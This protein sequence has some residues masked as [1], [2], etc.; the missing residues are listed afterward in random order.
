LKI[1][2]TKSLTVLA[3]KKSLNRVRDFAE[4]YGPKYGLNM[5][6]VNGFRLS[7]DEI[8]TNI[9][10]YAYTDR[11]IPG[12]IHIEI[13]R[14]EGTVVTRIIDNGKHFDYSTVVDPD[15]NRYIEERRR[16]GFGI[17]LVRQLNESVKYERV[18]NSNIL[19]LINEV[20]P[21][22]SLWH[23][24]QTNLS[25]VQMP[26][27][28]RFTLIAAL[29]ITL[30]TAGTFY[31]I[32]HLQ[33]NA[34]RRQYINSIVSTLR[35]FSATS[36]DYIL[37]ERDLFLAE[38]IYEITEENKE[39]K[40]LTVTNAD[41]R[42]VADTSL[43]N[44]GLQ[45]NSPDG[46]VPLENQVHL[47]QEYSD[48]VLGP[49]MYFSVPIRIVDQVIGKLFL[50]IQ[51]DEMMRIVL[52]SQDKRRIVTY[53]GMFWVLGIIGIYFL[54][55][56]FVAPI[57]KITEE[58]AR[59]SREGTTGGFHFT[60]V[61]EF[62]E[63]S[64]AF[65]QMMREIT[66]SQLRLTDQDRLKR[67]MQ[68]AQ[69]IQHTLLPKN[70]PKT[71]GYE[72]AAEYDAAMEVGGDYY[73]FFEVDENTV[74]MAVGDVS[75]KG[76]G[77]AFVMS[78]VRTALRLE[79]RGE[80]NAAEVLLKI[81]NSLDGEFKKGMYM[82]LFYIILDSRRRVINYASAG[83][84]P[85]ILYRGKTNQLFR[86]NPKGFPIGLNIGDNKLFKKNIKNEKLNLSKDDMLLI[87][88]DGITE[89]MNPEREVY[90]EERLFNLIKQHHMST[91]RE[92]ADKLTDDIRIFTH[93]HPQNDDIT[94]IVIKEK[95]KYSDLLF[96]K[97]VKLFE[98]VEQEG[99][100]VKKACETIGFSTTTY[101]NLKKLRDKGGIE[102]LKPQE[103]DK[104]MRV[105]DQSLSRKILE[106]VS[107][108]PDH[109][110]KKIKETLE[111]DYYGNVDI[112]TKLIYRELNR[113]KLSTK[114][115]RMAYVK[116]KRE[117]KVD[118]RLSLP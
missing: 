13:T 109:S 100:S 39:F 28:I 90:G 113:L 107:D 23:K 53:I 62:A 106:V 27:K 99:Y 61:G 44:L 85:M 5:R 76:I 7:L 112:D 67:E 105:L 73:D 81:N 30:I 15:L 59:V 111:T 52:L 116:R 8:C 24:I 16:G 21:R 72:I 84:T 79:A 69:S 38:M 51:T 1:G 35:N 48:P 87:Y 77:G 71:E 4:K 93:G 18:G 98:L 9:I 17:F 101:Y 32:N 65:N 68:L 36:V 82:T 104:K 25:P 57:K 12:N 46:V 118:K 78:I 22:P 88:T 50:T 64:T 45:Y 37:N 60:G 114:E 97:R 11:P 42:I 14:E 95:A 3:E 43:E 47:I 89:S 63:I 19:T 33:I 66:S 91:P 94:F 103:S 55:N 96:D 26:I 117:G 110:V 80:K 83:H 6:Q 92:F 2:K 75:G 86:M 31:L 20:E 56:I 108:H 74:G 58:I 10:Q 102:A 49:S 41:N 29:I 34:H 40:R 70:V 54:G 115:K